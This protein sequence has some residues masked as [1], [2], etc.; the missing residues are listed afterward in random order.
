MFTL[1]FTKK[2]SVV[3]VALAIGIMHA[4]LAQNEAPAPAKSEFKRI[5]VTGSN[6]K[7]VDVETASPVQ[8]ITREEMVR[9]GATS[10]NEVLRNISANVGGID[11]NRSNGFSAGAAGLNLRGL[12]TQATLVLINGRR[13][14]AYAQPEYQTTFVDLNSVP[15]GAVERIEVLKD[16]ASA[17]Y[18]SE[19]MAGVVN[20][21]MRDSFEGAMIDGSIGESVYKDGR[22]VRSSISVGGGSLV[23][24]H[25]NAYATLDIRQRKSMYIG[26]RPD[27]I[28]TQNWTQWGYK[29]ARSIYSFPGNIY[30][31]DKATGKFTARTLSTN[32]PAD[33]LTPAAVFLGAG[34]TGEYCNFDDLK[35]GSFNSAGKTDRIG[36]TSRATWQPNENVTVFAEAMLNQ[37]KAVVTGNLHWIAGQNGQPTPALP[38]THPQYPKELIGPDG[39][40]LA[41]GNG[42]VRVRAQFSDFPGQGQDNVTN[43]ARYLLGSK[44]AISTWDWETAVL[45]NTSKVTS[46]NSSGVLL[47][48]F[49]N[50]YKNGTLIFGGPNNAAL[51]DSVKTQSSSDFS[52]GVYQWDA[53]LSGEI[54]SL[55][56]GP[57]NMASG[58]EVRKEF[59]DTN[60][61]PQSVAGE[62][63]HQA[64]S[65][66]GF[67]N[68]RN[69]ASL[70]TELSIPV[71][72]NLEGSFAVRHD[73]YS[74]YGSSTTPK[75]GLKW[76][77][78]SALM[79]RGTVASGFRAPTLVE[80]ST[81]VRNAFTTVLDPERCNAQ[82][83]EG[84]TWQS[85][86]QSGAN[87]DLQPETA[88]SF[89]LGTVWEPT[90]WFNA[91]V[92]LFRIKRMNEIGVYDIDKVLADPARYASDPAVQITRAPL[93]DVDRAAGATAG[94]ITNIKSLL[95][96]I[97]ITELRGMDID[98]RGKF[99]MG[100]YGQL[101][102][103]VNLM[104][105]MSYK[106]APSPTD[107]LIEYAGTRG[108]PEVKAALGMD[109]KKAAWQLSA[110]VVFIGKMSSKDDFTQPCT[111]GEEG[112]EDLCNGIPSFTTINIGG[113]Y[114]GFKD[115][116][117]SAAIQN[118]LNTTPPFVPYTTRGIGYYAPLHDA[119]GR[120]LQLTAEYRF[121]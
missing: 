43:F 15:I 47:T 99:N 85:P 8:I 89:T 65:A 5:T 23:E 34:A 55:P 19:A 104:Y 50:A 10:L 117:I 75:L 105:T 12:G 74:D 14:A 87:P 71:L 28:G 73:R 52:S 81:D 39:K 36:I 1:R 21:I 77:L 114:K 42:T 92:D 51:F 66:P 116:K 119:T 58:V 11:E 20:I 7:R 27:Y 22:Q 120:Y 90:G 121:K 29:D 37:N 102:P 86:Y 97:S 83:K 18:G 46:N 118:V 106:S 45:V 24:D 84:C 111:V 107:D 64:Q 44:G 30:W 101:K 53:K 13:L 60:P 88:N 62:L 110:D 3:A 40:T 91:T 72:K 67:S 94:T 80:N 98:L 82:F 49:V 68:S 35:D 78:S 115:W 41:G 56:A 69:I 61:D 103:Y 54:M 31:T 32:C 9:G 70:Y 112:Y 109:W 57:L 4:A 96:N 33:R 59:L 2:S 63:Y 48:P 79:L 113:S 6:I 76:N 17:I 38:I 16:G 93:T 25:F 108:Q 95:T 100:E 26:N